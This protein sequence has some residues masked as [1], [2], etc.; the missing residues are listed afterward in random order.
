MAIGMQTLKHTK[1][2]WVG[3]DRVQFKAE[4]GTSSLFKIA[5]AK[6]IFPDGHVATVST[7]PFKTTLDYSEPLSFS[8]EYFNGIWKADLRESI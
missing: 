7:I 3:S 6:F 8:V 4:T 1:Y 2:Y 5:V